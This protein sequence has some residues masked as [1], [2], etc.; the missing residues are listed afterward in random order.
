MRIV[1]IR[2]ISQIFFLVLLIWFCIVTTLGV[3]WWQLR[4]WPV[5]WLLQLDPLVAVATMISTNSLYKGLLWALV[6]VIL[7][8]VLGRFFC[9]W[10]CP[11]GTIHHF[12]GYLARRGKGISAKIALNKYHPGQSIK[13]Y[14]LIFL[15]TAA[16][17]SLLS[18]LLRVV[19]KNQCCFP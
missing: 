13:Y 12:L 11:F 4:G 10:V 16:A 18:S 1:T 19:P 17:G 9:S 2:R 7:T 14:L 5:N 15:L 6:T 8:I 3:E